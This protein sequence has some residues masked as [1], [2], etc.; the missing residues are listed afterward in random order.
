MEHTGRQ[1][2]WKSGRFQSRPRSGIRLLH[3]A[4]LFLFAFLVGRTPFFGEYF[5]AA[6]ALTACL[7]SRN[8]IYIYLA[9]P[10]G[11]GIF[12]CIRTGVDAWSELIA[13][14]GCALLF[15]GVKKI[16]LDLWHRALIAGSVGILSLSTYRLATATV[17]K[18]GAGELLADGIMIAGF[19]FL[20][21]GFFRAS[22]EEQGGLLSLAGLTV[23][24]ILAVCG[25]GAGFLLWPAAIFLI[26]SVLCYGQTGETAVVITIAGIIA[27]L[28]G[29]TQW[30]FM[31]S[32]LMG[33]SAAEFFRRFGSIVMALVFTAVCWLLRMV[34][35]GLILGVDNYCLFLAVAAFAAVSWKCS[36]L[37][38]RMIGLFS[39]S[40][41][42]DFRQ[43]SQETFHLLQRQEEEM[44]TLAELYDTYVDSRSL[45]AAQFGVTSQ[46]LEHTRWQMEQALKKRYTKQGKEP[47]LHEK[48][49]MDIAV[50]QCAATGTI[51]GDC[52][53]WQDLGDGRTALVIS[54]GMGKGKR[55]AAESLLVTRTVLGL[56]KSGAGTEL[57]LKMINTIMMMKDGE[58]SFATVDL[59]VVDRRSGRT[60]FYKIGAAPTLIRRRNNIEEVRLSAVPLGIVNG[61]E[62]RSEE[63]FLKK[64]DF[65]IMM[66]DGVSD[67]PDG[68]GFL[69]QLAEILRSIRSGEP[70][71]ICDLVLDQVSDS[72]LGK[73]R[74]DLTIMTAKL[75]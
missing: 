61:L 36:S 70:A 69:P 32:L 66:S 51:N 68:R 31:L 18:T 35:S 12:C 42:E 28:A 10:A 47:F 34:E 46:M 74:D 19:F 7:A 9:I 73:E 56:L 57:T 29:Q 63:I 54:D 3:A 38:R 24:W 40:R 50:S 62:I 27:F 6:V 16:H 49:Q 2:T 25:T 39:G 37:L 22:K 14:I 67:G 45:L 48:F 59:A 17:N 30:G 21:E 15:A 72:Y 41:Q 33:A 1:T 13:V 8:P 26:L 64:G 60:K 53:G 11:A 65:L 20:W 4:L 23:A 52:C 5:P 75:L 43:R 58:D 71:V 55:A 44:K